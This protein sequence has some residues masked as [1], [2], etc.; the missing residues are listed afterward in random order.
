MRLQHSP[1]M[2]ETAVWEQRLCETGIVRSQQRATG[3]TL[4]VSRSDDED[5]R[6][7]GS[8]PPFPYLPDQL[9]DFAVL[10]WSP[11]AVVPG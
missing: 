8:R 10:Y 5:R 3:T 6:L 2:V 9:P 4:R 11:G 1:G 7:P